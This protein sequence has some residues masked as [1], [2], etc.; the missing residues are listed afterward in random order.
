MKGRALL[1]TREQ[2]VLTFYEFAA[3][4]HRLSVISDT[5]ADLW[6]F[7]YFLPVGVGRIVRLRYSDITVEHII[8]V[9]RGR[10]KEKHLLT[11]L[12]IKKIIQRRRESYPEDIFV[13]QSHSNRVKA[14]K[15][16]VTIIAFNRALKDASVGVTDHT[17]TSK[18]A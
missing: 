1:K 13:F 16:P 6:T 15:K 11:P 12:V 18:C 14:K 8:F 2:S 10:L 7:L 9:R 5:W 17:V 3:I 4:N